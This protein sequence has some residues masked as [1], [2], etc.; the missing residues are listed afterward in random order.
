MTPQNFSAYR[1]GVDKALGGVIKY[2]TDF[3]TEIKYI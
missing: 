1:Q 3:S 2:S